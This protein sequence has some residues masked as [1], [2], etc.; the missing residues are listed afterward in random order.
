MLKYYKINQGYMNSSYDNS[1]NNN[2][3]ILKLKAIHNKMCTIM[4]IKKFCDFKFLIDN[5][6]LRANSKK[7][8]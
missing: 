5:E 4:K 7:K 3:D 8:W 1:N 2:K 6:K